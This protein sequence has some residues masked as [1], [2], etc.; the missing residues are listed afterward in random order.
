MMLN[1]YYACHHLCHTRHLLFISQFR[2]PP[3]KVG[4]NFPLNK[5]HQIISR[6]KCNLSD[7][8]NQMKCQVLDKCGC[9]INVS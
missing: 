6:L 4:S 9:L 2:V 8:E 7:I 3:L 1:F 5:L